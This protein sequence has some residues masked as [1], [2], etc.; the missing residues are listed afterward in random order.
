MARD[1]AHLKEAVE[2]IVRR[3]DDEHKG[4]GM[5]LI[6]FDSRGPADRPIVMHLHGV[7]EAV[8]FRQIAALGD[9]LEEVLKDKLDLGPEIVT[10]PRIIKP[11]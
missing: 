8:A 6:A 5:I 3:V 1:M 11:S 4:L 9:R 2:K 10:G 7:D